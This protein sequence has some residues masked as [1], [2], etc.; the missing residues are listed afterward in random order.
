MKDVKNNEDDL[1]M[2]SFRG[3]GDGLVSRLCYN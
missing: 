2:Y 3:N 1:A